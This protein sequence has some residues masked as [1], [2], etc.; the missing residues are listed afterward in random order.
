MVGKGPSSFN[1]SSVNPDRSGT[2]DLVC[3]SRTTEHRRK[4]VGVYVVNIIFMVRERT[5]SISTRVV[6]K[7]VITKLNSFDPNRDLGSCY[8]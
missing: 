6:E 3:W 4:R 7:V 5:G 2:C 8:V 1:T